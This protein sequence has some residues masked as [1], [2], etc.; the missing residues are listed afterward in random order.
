MFNLIEANKQKVW[1][2]PLG[3]LLPDQMEKRK[4]KISYHKRVACQPLWHWK[5]LTLHHSTS[6]FE[7]IVMA[8]RE[9]GVFLAC[10]FSPD[11]R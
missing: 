2:L 7:E 4:E 3:Q 11:T 1:A 10:H 9:K 5:L 6:G 8:K